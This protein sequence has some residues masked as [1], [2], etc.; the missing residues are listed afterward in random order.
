MPR[1]VSK[2]FVVAIILGVVPVVSTSADEVTIRSASITDTACSESDLTDLS[3]S[4]P[5]VQFNS[6]INSIAILTKQYGF[7]GLLGELI[8]IRATDS[9]DEPFEITYQWLGE[10]QKVPD[11]IFSA[12]FTGMSDF[13]D[14]NVSTPNLKTLDFGRPPYP[15]SDADK[16]AIDTR[17]ATRKATISSKG[18]IVGG[19]T[20][21]HRDEGFR[22]NRGQPLKTV[23]S[24][25]QKIEFT[26]KESVPQKA[27][28]STASVT[29]KEADDA[30]SKQDNDT[31]N[32]S[33][34]HQ[35]DGTSTTDGTSTPN[36]SSD[37]NETDIKDAKDAKDAKDEK[38]SEDS[39]SDNSDSDN[40]KSDNDDSEDENESELSAALTATTGNQGTGSAEFKSKSDD[41]TTKRRFTLDVSDA[42]TNGT[43]VTGT[44]DVIVGGVLVGSID[45]TEGSGELEFRTDA[46][47][48]DTPF[49]SNFPTTIDSTTTVA[50]GP[51]NAPILDGTFATSTDSESSWEHDD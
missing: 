8:S 5:L 50:I 38:D 4:A 48:D 39:Q 10:E 32:N 14:T 42:K 26:G 13:G 47:D 7:V 3:F 11:A 21:H 9:K 41:G 15:K 6:V 19:V 28:T 49:P 40:D 16:I 44:Q 37:H 34:D 18:N 27:S 25:T 43:L 24:E 35:I 46:D 12:E 31:D 2:V 17:P 1:I 23:P 22:F 29:M 51:A 30:G 33:D 20:V 45:L 36:K